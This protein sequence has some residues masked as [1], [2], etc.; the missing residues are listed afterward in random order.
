[1]DRLYELETELDEV[2]AKLE[3]SS[4]EEYKKLL[5]EVDRIMCE[6][7]TFEDNWV[8]ETSDVDTN[9]L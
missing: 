2:Q 1:M 7:N 4:G 9:E 6:L 5:K 8:P 3:E